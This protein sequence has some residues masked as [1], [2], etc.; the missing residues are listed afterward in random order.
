MRPLSRYI[1]VTQSSSEEFE[2][3]CKDQCPRC[4][5]GDPLR[6]RE[7]SGEFVHDF[8]FGMFEPKIG[9]PVGMGHGICLA[10]DLRIK[11]GNGIVS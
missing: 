1:D 11:R 8:S 5:A 6:Y 7:D 10:H 4:A 9:R 3:L 2:Q